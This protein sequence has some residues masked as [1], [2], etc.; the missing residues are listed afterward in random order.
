MRHV[1]EEPNTEHAIDLNS[2]VEELHRLG[3]QELNKLLRESNNFTLQH[4][5]ENGSLILIDMERLAWSLP[6]HLIAVLVS[7]GGDEIRLR[8]LL[9]GFRL[10][11]SLSD[12]ASR[13]TKLEQILLDEVKVTEQILDLVFYMLVVLAR[14]EQENHVPDCLPLLHSALVACSF[15]LL[16][17]YISSQWQDIVHVLLAHPKVDVFMDVAFDAVR[18]DI[19]FLQVKL[20]ALNNDLL[21]T[22]YSLPAAEKIAHSLC[23]QC[24]ASLQFLHSLCQQKLFR[25][26]VLKNKELC[27]NGGILSLA[28]AVLKLDTPQYFRE[29]SNVVAAISRLKSKVL[30]ILLQLCETESVSY[31]DEV[32]ST[33]RSMQLAKSVA[34]EVLELLKTDFGRKTKLLNDCIG[35]SYPTGLVLLNSMRLTDIFSDDSNFRYFITTNITHILAEA[36]SLPHEEFLPSWC[37]T[38]L[39]LMEEDATLEYD[40]FVAAGVVLV[41]LSVGFG[42]SMPLNDKNT[43]CNFN[44][45]GLPQASY[46]QQRTSLLVKIIANLHCFVPDVC[47]EQERNLFFNKFL[48]CLQM[49]LPK[50]HSGPSSTF[51]AQKAAAVCKNLCSLLDHAASLIPN[52]LNEEDENLLSKFFKQLQ[53][54]LPPSQCE[55]TSVQEV[56]R[57]KGGYASPLSRKIDSKGREV[58]SDSRQRSGDLKEGT[59]ESFP[60][61]DDLMD[62]VRSKGKGTTSRSA[63][64]SLREIDK[65]VRNVETSGSDASS[66]RGKNSFDQMDNGDYPN[67][68]EHSKESGLRGVADVNERNE[69]TNSEEKQRRKRK[70]NIMNDKQINLIEHALLDEPEMQ[71]NA[72]LLYSWADKL[73]VHVSEISLLFSI[74]L[75]NRKARLAKAARESQTPSE[76]DNALPDKLGGAHFFDSPPDSPS[77]E[78]VPSSSTRRGGSNQSTPKLGVT[79]RRTGSNENY[80]VVATEFSDAPAH[81]SMQ[82]KC[83]SLRYG[84]EPGQNVSLTD[85]EGK[86]IGRGKIYQVEGRWHGK[87]LEEEKTFVVDVA[88]LMV[89]RW[90]SLPHP[91]EAAGTTF[92]EAEAKNGVMRV[93]WDTNNIL[94]SPQ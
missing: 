42:T 31:L 65:D 16:T 72:A 8:Y 67:L 40:P 18:V 6:L 74:W 9:C 1:K 4:Y 51:D 30:S 63:S 34:L 73:S 60:S 53:S 59:S 43:E 70:R 2:A 54:L 17:G 50:S 35:D 13:H 14:Y 83:T 88:N 86:E 77:E 58:A 5:T 46:A 62:L 37:S 11:H 52:F 29:S 47:E 48:E 93:A 69:F 21:C 71:R 94:L 49:E 24:E 56:V 90:T 36:L 44:I 82:M 22:K 19:K 76:G 81:Q 61:Q 84:Y 33:E 87:S 38:D 66:S 91:S 75:N 55:A 85:G 26:R 68:S 57:S 27:K 64:E 7:P 32:A 12:V 15:H 23:Q 25:E 20:S 45:I 41:S 39:P 3:S 92:S 89:D 10:L 80:E 28:R 79:L 78:Y